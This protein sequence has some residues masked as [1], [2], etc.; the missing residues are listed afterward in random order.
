MDECHHVAAKTL[1]KVGMH[2]KDS[3]MIGLSA[4]P[5]RDDGEDMK[6]HAVLGDIVYSIPINKLVEQGYLLP[7]EV[8]MLQ[9]EKVDVSL[10]DDYR[11]IYKNNIVLNESRNQTVVDTALNVCKVGTC[12]VMVEQIEHGDLL[13]DM[14]KKQSKGLKVVFVNGQSD[15]RDKIFKKAIDS[16]YDII[17]ATKV[18]NEGVSISCLKSMIMGGGGKGT[19]KVVQQVGR[20][21][22]H[23]EGKTKATI[24]DFND[25]CKI[26]KRHTAKR[27][28]T[29]NDCGFTI[30]EEK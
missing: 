10:F 25:N 22:R 15:D 26:L 13:L 23:Y 5:K 24:Y 20:L 17:I 8:H 18:Y 9:V 4:T 19:S 12:L 11:D 7:A 29:Y 6:M 27:L 14:I 3:I 2:C 16:H 28:K 30:K 21:L 1:Y